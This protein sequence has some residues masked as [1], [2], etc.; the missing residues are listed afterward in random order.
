MEKTR[1]PKTVDGKVDFNLRDE[2]GKHQEATGK[3]TKT[4]RN[5][6]APKYVRLRKNSREKNSKK[7]NNH[8]INK[9][10]LMYIKQLKNGQRDR[11]IDC[12]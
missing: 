12:G 3:S 4:F 1:I 5:H 6:S 10:N 8:G 7:S 2:K 9:I 11:V